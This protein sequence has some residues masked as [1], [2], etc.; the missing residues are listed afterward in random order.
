VALSETYVD[1]SIAANSGTGTI[2]DPY[3]DLQ[4]ALDTMTRDSTNGDRI[5]IKAGTDEILAATISLA[6]Y[7]S[8][9]LSAPLIF[10]GYTSTAGDGGKGG[11]D[12]NTFQFYAGGTSIGYV[13]LVPHNCATSAIG[14][15]YRST[16]AR[17]E[18][19]DIGTDA[20]ASMSEAVVVSCRFHDIGGKG[21]NV[22]S[23]LSSFIGGCYF[24]NGTKDMTICI[25]ALQGSAASSRII[26]NVFS[27]DSTTIAIEAYWNA[28]V[29]GNSILCDGGT[30]K[31]IYVSRGITGGVFNNLV[32]GFSG[33]GGIGI[34]LAGSEPFGVV[35]CNSV[36]DCET[37]YTTPNGAHLDESNESL[38]ASPFAKSGPDTYA[39]RSTYFE[40]QDVGEVLT[41][42]LHNEARGAIQPAG[43][44]ASMLRRSNFRGGY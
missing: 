40:P 7:G 36:Y 3:G 42:L 24:Q 34:H 18:F 12:C 28:V 38:A 19:H 33:V 9:S 27:I 6:T 21:I 35:A 22:A 8:P 17:V 11:I 31:G 1:P 44:A 25:D 5:N 43:G 10:Q 37:D 20:I 13:D 4:Y 15:L 39:L 30:G 41:G 32:E 14:N 2:G 26:G 16:C 29:S 23:P